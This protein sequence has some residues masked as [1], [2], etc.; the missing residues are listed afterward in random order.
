MKILI[1]IM[2]ALTL[3]FSGCSKSKDADPV[4]QVKADDKAMNDAIAKAKASSKDFVAAFHAKK[5]G[6]N[7]FSVKKPYP[8]PDGG[9]E[10]MWIDVTDESN[11]IIQGIVANDADATLEVK[12]GQKVSLKLEEISDWKYQDGKKMIGGYTVRYFIDRMSPKE[13]EEF[14]KEAGFEL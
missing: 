1:A 4:I 8:T 13:R 5:S 7:A 2:M 6:T 14:L 3:V 10:H 12:L 9:H 11:G